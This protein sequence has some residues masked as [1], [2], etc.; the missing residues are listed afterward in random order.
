MTVP[1]IPSLTE[2]VGRTATAYLRQNFADSEELNR[3]AILSSLPDRRRGT[4]VDLGCGDGTFTARVARCVAA[5]H[6]AGVEI[7]E[8]LAKAAEGRGIE[9]HRSDIEAGLPFADASVDVVH[10]NQVIEHLRETDRFMAEIRRVLR[11]DGCAVISTNNLA[12]LHNIVTLAAGWQPPAAHVSDEHVGVGNPLDPFRGTPGAHGQ[13]HL[14]LFTGRALSEL[15]LAHGLRLERARTAGFYPLPG[16]AAELA[17]ALL[18]RWGVYLVQRF[19][20]A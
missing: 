13:M 5:D 4:L 20:P 3:R 17:T 9:V 14:R 18:P 2:A 12:S 19:G 10:A 7:V 16:R 1:P 11:A 6:V 8:H 15:A